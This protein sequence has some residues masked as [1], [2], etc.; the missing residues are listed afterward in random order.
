MICNDLNKVILRC[1]IE[2]NLI[3]SNNIDIDIENNITIS[4]DKDI[5]N[6]LYYIKN[7]SKNFHTLYESVYNSKKNNL[8][9]I[10]SN[11]TYTSYIFFK[12]MKEMIYKQIKN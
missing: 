3:K 8:L 12:N 5:E 4:I 9:S 10:I 11:V 2:N 7:P 1:D 6:G